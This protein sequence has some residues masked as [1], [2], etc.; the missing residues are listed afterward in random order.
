MS[1][2]A[3]RGQIVK[4]INRLDSSGNVTGAIYQR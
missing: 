1:Q 2:F 3:P 4:R